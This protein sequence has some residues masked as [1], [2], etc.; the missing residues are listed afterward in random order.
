[1]KN[2]VDEDGNVI[3]VPPEEIESLSDWCKPGGPKSRENCIKFLLDQV[4]SNPNEKDFQDFTAL[5]YACI[6]G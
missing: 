2:G 6:W 4:G 5:H 3:A 1:L